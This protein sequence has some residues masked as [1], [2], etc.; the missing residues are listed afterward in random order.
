MS[1][2][3]PKQLNL[4]PEKL[5]TQLGE[6][7]KDIDATA[8][9]QI[10][11]IL[12]NGPFGLP[13]FDNRKIASIFGEIRETGGTEIRHLGVDFEAPIGTPV[14]AMNNG[15]VRKAYVDPVYGNSV[16]VDHGKGIFSLYMHLNEMRVKEGGTVAKGTVVGT[17]GKT[18]YATSPHLHLSVK[19]NSV[20]VDPLRFVRSF[21]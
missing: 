13:L 4:T 3:I 18:G 20:S 8:R 1:L 11:T 16:I 5:I 7:K 17:V 15:I 14:G 9:V 21:K 12:F 19:I 6:A 2:G 10:D